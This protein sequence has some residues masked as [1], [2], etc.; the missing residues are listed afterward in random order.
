MAAGAHRGGNGNGDAPDLVTQKFYEMDMQALSGL[1]RDMTR[2][3]TKLNL[4][5]EKAQKR[6]DDIAAIRELLAKTSG[7]DASR[8]N[9]LEQGLAEMGSVLAENAKLLLLLVERSEPEPE[10][11]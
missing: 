5:E 3:L 11:V 2:V 6:A 8:L 1:R 7:L 10:G 9:A 4:I